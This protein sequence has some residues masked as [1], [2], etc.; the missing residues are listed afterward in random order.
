MAAGAHIERRA[1]V[2]IETAGPGKLAGYASVFGRPSADLGGFVETVQRGAFT[3]SLAD[4]GAVLALYDHD[5]RAVLG[6]AGAGTLRLAEDQRGL[7]FEVDLPDT[8]LGRDLAVLVERGDVAGGSIGFRVREGGESWNL[9][10]SP[11]QRTLSDLELIEVTITSLPAYA[12]TT[13]AKRYMTG[14]INAPSLARRRRML[15]MLEVS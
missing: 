6:R 5:R 15:T 11:A 12:D 9:D 7:A 14:L 10:A 4:P 2:S 1:A 13:V 3:K 8:S